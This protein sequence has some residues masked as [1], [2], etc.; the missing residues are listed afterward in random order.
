[1]ETTQK[2]VTEVNNIL[3]SQ[4]E[5]SAEEMKPEA[6]LFTD[7]GLD[8]LDAIDMVIAFQNKF[9]IKLK[10]EDIQTI[11]TLGDIH[12]LIGRYASN[13]EVF[14]T[15]DVKASEASAGN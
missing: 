7:L 6:H 2:Y 13:L 10:D 3:I 8:S 5:F 14:A 11:R 15:T 1:M 4:F 9:G 12:N